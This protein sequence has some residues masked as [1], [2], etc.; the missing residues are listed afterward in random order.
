MAIE[1]VTK[2]DLQAFRLPLVSDGMPLLFTPA[3]H[4]TNG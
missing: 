4:K 2:E 3:A 1:I